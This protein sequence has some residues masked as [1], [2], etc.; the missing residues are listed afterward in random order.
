ML[1]IITHYISEKVLKTDTKTTNT[2]CQC[3]PL[4]V[5]SNFILK[6]FSELRKCAKLYLKARWHDDMQLTHSMAHG[7][8][9]CK[10]MKNGRKMPHFYVSSC[11][12]DQ[13]NR[14]VGHPE[15]DQTILAIKPMTTYYYI[16][17]HSIHS[18]LF[19]HLFICSIYSG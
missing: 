14:W 15:G 7:K 11:S 19:I 1:P 12:E 18:F 17:S 9:R 4:I 5:L 2:P 6:M 3:L 16:C 13:V 8:Q 10:M